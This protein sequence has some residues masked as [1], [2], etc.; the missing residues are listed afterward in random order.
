MHEQGITVSTSFVAH[1]FR[2]W[3]WSWQKPCVQQLQKYTP[4][5]ICY[6]AQFISIIP[7][8]PP[9]RLKFLDEAHFVSRHLQRNRIISPTGST[10]FLRTTSEISDSFSLTLLTD[11][12]DPDIPFFIDMRA[13]SNT[14]WDY[15]SFISAALAAGRLLPGDFLFVD[16]ASIHFGAETRPFLREMLNNAG[17][18]YIFLP[19]YSPELNPCELVFANVKHFIRAQRTSTSF[20][21]QLVV[22]ALASISYSSLVSFYSHCIYIQDR[23]PVT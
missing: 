21:P 14:E 9:I 19:T 7:C 20:V 8:L 3:R 12:S 23:S 18:H 17:V 5:N 2:G 1:I 15:A 10:P 4:L 6:Y 13:N 22:D 16:N 11:L